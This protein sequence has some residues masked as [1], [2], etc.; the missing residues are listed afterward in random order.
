MGQGHGPLPNTHMVPSAGSV[1]TFP[2]RREAGSVLALGC[3]LDNTKTGFSYWLFI[4]FELK[5]QNGI[6]FKKAKHFYLVM[7]VSVAM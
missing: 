4:S 3:L 5:V 1:K 2:E 6:I 7:Q